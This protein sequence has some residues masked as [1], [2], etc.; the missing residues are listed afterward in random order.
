M[1]PGATITVTQTET[2]FTRSDVTD[3]NGAYVLPNLPVGPYRLEVRMPPFTTYAQ[4]GSSIDV[5]DQ[6]RISH[7]VV[8]IDQ[9]LGTSLQGLS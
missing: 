9:E 3:S 7:G 1:L 6:L 5:V 2:G 8:S 4:T